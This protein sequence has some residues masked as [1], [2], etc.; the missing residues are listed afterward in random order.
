V[1]IAPVFIWLAP[2]RWHGFS[3]HC[4]MKEEIN[5]GGKKV[6][7]LIEPHQVQ[8]GEG[9]QPEEY[10]TASYATTDPPSLPG[11]ILFLDEGEMPKRFLSP[12]QALEFANEK[13]LGLI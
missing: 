5:V 7:V 3:F 1:F 9:N 4:C 10:F 8:D 6:W 2:I 11:G 13:L 12:V